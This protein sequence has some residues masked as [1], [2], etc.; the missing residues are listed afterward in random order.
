MEPESRPHHTALRSGRIS[1]ANLV[2]A[3][4]TCVEGRLKRLVPDP[5]HPNGAI[6]RAEIIVSC[7]RWLHLEGRITCHGYVVMPDHVHIVFAL[8]HLQTL[9][10]V[11]GSFGSF[12][13]RQLNALDRTKRRFWQSGFYDHAIRNHEDLRA[14]IDYVLANPVRRG[15]VLSPEDWPFGMAYPRWEAPHQERDYLL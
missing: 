8:G 6:E 5:H 15:Y 1:V 4:T 9:S 13:A 11:M 12:T 3:V 7:L 2:Y 10:G 14:K